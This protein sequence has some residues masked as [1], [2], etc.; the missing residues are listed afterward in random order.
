MSDEEANAAPNAP[1][2]D[3]E[4]K[5]FEVVFNEGPMGL[6]ITDTN[7]IKSTVAGGQAAMGGVSPGDHLVEV[8]GESVKGLVH[9]DMVEKIKAVGRPVRLTFERSGDIAEEEAT[10]GTG[11]APTMRTR[12]VPKLMSASEAAGAV[13]K[14]GTFMKGL[15]GSGINVIAGLDK[16]VGNALDV[17]IGKGAVRAAA[18]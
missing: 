1:R 2:V 3:S 16:M 7:I 15:L 11:A 5:R 17:S 18:P 14:A 13:K 4:E 8:N 12:F 6:V 10:G 9:D